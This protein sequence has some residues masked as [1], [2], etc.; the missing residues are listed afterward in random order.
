MNT[1]S[2]LKRTE[3]KFWRTHVTCIFSRSRLALL[4]H[5]MIGNRD[6]H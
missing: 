4:C 6:L 1:N 2:I 5:E 3:L